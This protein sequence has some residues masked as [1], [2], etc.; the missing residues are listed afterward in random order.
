MKKFLFTVRTPEETCF[1][2]EVEYVVLPTREGGYGVLVNHAP[3]VLW[4]ET[5]MC[6]ATTDGKKENVFIMGGVADITREK[7]TVLADFAAT[8]QNLQE[9]LKKREEYYA[10]EKS[11]RKGS[12]MAFKKS[13]RELVRALDRLSGKGEL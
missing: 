6:V 7:V 8:E 11:R 13:S 10:G 1:E 5:G 3:T 12:F 2:K 4:V 9:A